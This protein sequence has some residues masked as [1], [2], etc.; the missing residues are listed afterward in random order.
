VRSENGETPRETPH[1]CAPHFM[2][3]IA[4]HSNGNSTFNLYP[5]GTD[6]AGNGP[7]PTFIA[8]SADDL[9]RTSRL[10][11]DLVD[12]ATSRG[13]LV[14]ESVRESWPA[15]PVGSLQIVRTQCQITI[16]LMGQQ[17]GL[18]GPPLRWS[19]VRCAITGSL[20]KVTIQE[21][22]F[23]PS[24]NA[25]TAGTRRPKPWPRCI[26][27]RDGGLARSCTWLRGLSQRV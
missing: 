12:R 16:Q 17:D 26:S 4:K 19:C 21:V 13:M 18:Q 3:G 8:L 11:S 2:G 14:P 1:L 6:L 23:V 20:I 15:Q 24:P 27:R 5:R 10:S 25:D 9:R 7:S 22:L